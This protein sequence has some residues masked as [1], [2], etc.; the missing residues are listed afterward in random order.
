MEESFPYFIFFPLNL[1]YCNVNNYA[2][3][4]QIEILKLAEKPFYEVG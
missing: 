2:F 1:T 4:Y 3:N